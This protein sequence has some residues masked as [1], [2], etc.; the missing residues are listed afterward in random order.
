MSIEKRPAAPLRIL[1]AGTPDFA[2]PPLRALLAAG[3]TVA[4]VY[5]QPDRPAG[6]GRRLTASPVKQCA[7]EH[8]L[9]VRQPERL[10]GEATL[11][12]LRA[13][14][15]DLMVVAAYGL[16][17][18]KAVL[19]LPRLGCINI[20]ASL[21]PRWRG[22][23]PIQRAIL[24]GDRETGVTLMRMAQGLDTG[25]ML[26]TL[27]CPITP[28]TTGGQLHD[29]L[30][31]LGAQALM[32]ALPAIRS[33]QAPGIPQDDAQATYAHKLEKA[34]AVVAWTQSAQAID[35]QIR[36]FNPWPV[37]QTTLRG[38]TLRLWEA[39]PVPRE[40]RL[41][42]GV[43]MDAKPKTGLIVACGQGALNLRRVQLP[44]K[45]PVDAAA[46]LHAHD[47]DGVVLG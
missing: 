22:A 28:T 16:I 19:A 47:M 23:A 41:E 25:A 24:A 44:G 7:L 30:I 40:H 3:H 29:R 43:V 10:R 45:T 35:R 21:L 31:E 33:G 42:P 32:E 8:G 37:A 9:P 38:K 46:F 12:E 20:H 36:A 39:E 2:V 18:P 4:A 34:E 11:A 15:P 17:L 27:R 13:F 14:A 5:T 1:Y 26:H 6:R